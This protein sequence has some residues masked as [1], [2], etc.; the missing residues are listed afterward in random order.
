MKSI[1]IHNLLFFLI[2]PFLAPCQTVHI[3]KDNIAY[4]GTVS[5]EGA[6]KNELYD[7]AKNAI[8]KNVK[9]NAVQ[10]D[11]AKEEIVSNGNI[12][13]ASPFGIVRTLKYKIKISV[14]ESSYKYHIDSVFI[15]QRERGEKPVEI[16]SADLFKRMDISGPVSIQTEKELNE[17]DM[18]FQKL[19]DLINR[20]MRRE[21]SK[22]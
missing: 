8:I 9:A 19:L 4:K 14:K 15:Q 11:S 17:I 21:A 5:V 10:V 7:R 20:E 2:L 1:S 3:E 13:L 18:Q 22:Q 16:S 6:S 12:T